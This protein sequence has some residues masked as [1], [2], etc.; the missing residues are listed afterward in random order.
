MVRI[1]K[2]LKLLTFFLFLLLLYANNI[3][4]SQDVPGYKNQIKIS[5]IKTVNFYNPGFEFSYEREYGKFSTQVI[6]AYL[7][8]CFHITSYEDYSGY[9]I[10][11]EEKLFYF[12]RKYFRQ[13]FSLE[14]G[15]Y[16]ASMTSSAYFV[17]KDIKKDDDLYY[18]SQYEDIFKLK[19]TG[20]I[21]DAK[22]GMQFLIKR[23]RIDLNVGLGIIIHNITHLNRINPD[24][25]MVSPIDLTAGYMMENNGRHVMPNFPVFPYTL[26]LGYAF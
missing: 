11:F 22:Y 15:Y 12:T 24:D 19:R 21:I 16:F 26:M 2:K 13:Y 23:F 17:P 10:M 18:E 5:P 8:D 3:V 7:V 6:A 9:R 1:H 4:F 25:E 14:V 20:V